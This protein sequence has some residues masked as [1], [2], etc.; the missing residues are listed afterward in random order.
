M[1]AREHETAQNA[2]AI[3]QAAYGR[4]AGY[5]YFTGCSKGGSEAPSE[6]RRIPKS[7]TASSVALPLL[8][9]CITRWTRFGTC[10]SE[11]D[12]AQYPLGARRRSADPSYTTR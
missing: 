10:S 11:W 2:K 9:V 5:S 4:P 6:V 12:A 7:S 3:V 8:T 1:D